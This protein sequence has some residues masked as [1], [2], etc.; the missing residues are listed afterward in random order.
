[1]FPNEYHRGYTLQKCLDPNRLKELHLRNRQ[2][3]SHLRSSYP[4][5]TQVS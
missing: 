5:E 4:V 1:M 3:P 2:Q